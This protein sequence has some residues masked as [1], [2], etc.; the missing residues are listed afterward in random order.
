MALYYKP[1]IS[2]ALSYGLCN[3]GFT[4]FYLP[5]T[6]EPYLPLLPSHKMLLPFGW[7]S[8]CL[9]WRDGQAV[10][11][12]GKSFFCLCLDSAYSV[13]W[14]QWVLILHY[15]LPLILLAVVI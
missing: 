1:F 5:P 12:M 14:A 15:H 10:Y 11:F 3:N 2:K 4:Q 8:L 7:Y 9:P 13:N 6:Y